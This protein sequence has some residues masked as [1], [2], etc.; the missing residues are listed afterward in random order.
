MKQRPRIEHYCCLFSETYADLRAI[1]LLGLTRKQYLDQ[2][3]IPDT[4]AG[5]IALRR[6]VVTAVLV[7][8]GQETGRTGRNQRTS[9]CT[10]SSGRAWRPPPTTLWRKVFPP[11]LFYDLK[12]Y[13]CECFDHTPTGYDGEKG[14]LFDSLR[15]T[16]SALTDNS[17]IYQLEQRLIQFINDYADTMPSRS[18]EVLSALARMKEEFQQ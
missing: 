9:A 1:L 10:A 12:E 11:C 13:L 16:F 17:S 3:F 18:K 6:L 2:Q 7:E 4:F 14:L 5:D 15:G 8:K